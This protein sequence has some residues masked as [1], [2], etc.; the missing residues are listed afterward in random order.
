MLTSNWQAPT[1]TVSFDPND[2]T[3]G[4]AAVS[5]LSGSYALPLCTFTA[6]AGKEF[7][8]WASPSG[9]Q[10]SPGTPVTVNAD[11]T[12]CAVWKSLV[13]QATVIG[14][15]GSGEY[16]PGESVAITAAVPDGQR[17]VSWMS[18]DAVDFA[19]K[20]A[21]ATTF[22]M[23]DSDVT[24]TAVTS[25][26]AQDAPSSAPELAGSTVSSITLKE[27]AV[28]AN[29]AAAQYGISADGGRTWAWQDSPEF[30]N[31][32]SGTEYTFAVRY[33]ATED[34]H[35][36]ASPASG[37]AVFSTTP[38]YP[39]VPA[40]TPTVEGADNGSVSVTPAS[41]KQGDVVTITPHP[42]KGY[43]TGSVAVTDSQGSPI[44]VTDNGDGTWSFIQP[45]GKV[46][47]EVT[48]TEIQRPAAGLPFTDVP[49]SA[50]Y[51]DA[52]VWAVENGVTAGASA[53]MFDPD[54]PCTRAQ[55][56]TFLWRA[57]GSPEPVN[58]DCPFTDL[59]P[60]DYYY[61][62]VLWA[63]ENGITAGTSA[64][65]FSPDQTCTRAQ[66]VTFLWRAA[67]KPAASSAP[68]FTDVAESAY[69]Y[70]AVAWAVERGVTTGVTAAAFSPNTAC[71]RAQIV[72]FLY[73]AEA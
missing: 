29:G 35:Y 46:T 16:M 28:N 69:Y 57:A 37:T 10:Y 65:T 50:Y 71:T 52:V 17:F 55:A 15:S 7:I 51:Y 12:F 67:G 63:V 53:T 59:Q 19:D 18:D 8:A 68:G 42:D 34:G 66:I 4:I 5:G 54:A 2:G 49:E 58:A 31:L 20:Y 23:P 38:L 62:A 73:R 22:I 45:A 24:V 47:V 60:G 70:G 3:D 56:V 21:A 41:P 43:E 13:C 61:K 32:A 25:S 26:T 72:T 36:V 9:T 6:P 40:Y 30:T 27:I 64:A 1:Y 44:R 14:G 11:A 48:F 39:T 33:G